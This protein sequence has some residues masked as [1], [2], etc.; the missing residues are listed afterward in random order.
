MGIVPE[1]LT[2]EIIKDCTASPYGDKCQNENSLANS[3]SEGVNVY[4]L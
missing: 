3:L 4:D 1:D 2:E